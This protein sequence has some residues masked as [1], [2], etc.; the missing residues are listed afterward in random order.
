MIPPATA[1]AVARIGPRRS[2]GYGGGTKAG[3]A[4]GITRRLT[5]WLLVALH[6][7][8]TAVL[9]GVH[10]EV[11]APEEL[12]R[13]GVAVVGPGDADAHGRHQPVVTEVDR[14]G[15]HREEPLRHLHR[16]ARIVEVAEHSGELVTTQTG[17]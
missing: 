15:D 12:A 1:A 5:V 6:A 10:G 7:R 4:E 11:G 3:E 16:L 2:W 14:L 13:G 8:A 17:D 9:G